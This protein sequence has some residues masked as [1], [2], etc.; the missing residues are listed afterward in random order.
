MD[1]ELSAMIAALTRLDLD[2]SR[3]RLALAAGGT[4]E[5]AVAVTGGD[6]HTARRTT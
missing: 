4:Q 3:A 2:A 5:D 6:P 1:P